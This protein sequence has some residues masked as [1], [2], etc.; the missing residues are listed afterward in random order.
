MDKGIT[1]FTC[2]PRKD[3]ECDDKGPFYYGGDNV[4]MTD[5][6]EIGCGKGYTWGSSSCSKCGELS[7]NT[8][9]WQDWDK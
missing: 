6:P 8:A 2:G 1:V 9:V 5:K 3:H 7:M 4:P